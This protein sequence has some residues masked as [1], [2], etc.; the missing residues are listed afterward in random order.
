MTV[1]Q[2]A[3]AEPA[4]KPARQ[5]VVGLADRALSND[6][7][8]TIITFALGSCLGVTIWD[9]VAKVGGLVHLMLPESST[10][11]DK[12]ASQPFMFID[13]G[14]PRFFKEAY[15]MG[16]TKERLIVCVAGG[17][18]LQVAGESTFQ[19]GA[20]NM[21]ALRKLFWKNGVLISAQ[22]TGGSSP[23]TMSLNIG[24]GEVALKTDSGSRVLSQGDKHGAQSPGSR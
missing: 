21:T 5:R 11:P 20:R 12:G 1:L 19:I 3:Q 4:P 18:A 24:S 2:W 23:R 15:A 22:E 10:N 7:A 13:T 8:E 14:V 16:A 9:P 6:E 17:A